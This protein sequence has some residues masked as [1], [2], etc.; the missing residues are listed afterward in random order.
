M[1]QKQHV[2]QNVCLHAFMCVYAQSQ[3]KSTNSQQIYIFGQHL[4]AQDWDL[5]KC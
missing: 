1:S 4:C 2:L 3:L 5:D